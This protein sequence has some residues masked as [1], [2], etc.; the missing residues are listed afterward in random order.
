MAPLLTIAA[1]LTLPAREEP[2]EPVLTPMSFGMDGLLGIEPALLAAMI[3][4]LAVVLFNR[5][6]RRWRLMHARPPSSPPLPNRGRIVADVLGRPASPDTLAL[7]GTRK[8]TSWKR[9]IIATGGQ[10]DALGPDPVGFINYGA[11]GRF[12]ALV[13][14]RN[15]P[16]PASLPPS[17][18]EKI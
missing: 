3:A 15:R 11:D 13:T 18:A 10:L 4:T 16:R 5:V 7:L 6:S 12:Y 8:M 9:E 2:L 17:D 1:P 14:S